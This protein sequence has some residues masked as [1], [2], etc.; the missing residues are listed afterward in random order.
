M[1]SHNFTATLESGREG[2]VCGMN[3]LDPPHARPA[4]GTDR[5]PQ[6]GDRSPQ[7]DDPS[8]TQQLEQRGHVDG[9]GL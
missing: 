6:S 5:D 2:G 1:S 8:V 3:E 4:N 9:V 7:H